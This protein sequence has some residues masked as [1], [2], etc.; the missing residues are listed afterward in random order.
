MPRPVSTDFLQ[1]MRFHVDVVAAD[2][3]PRLLRPVPTG[4]SYPQSGF[5][6][7]TIPSMSVDTVDYREGTF[8]YTRRQ[9]GIPSMEDIT[10]SRGVA[11]GDSSFF[12]WMRQVVEGTG[13]YRATLEIRHY[14]RDNTHIRSGQFPGQFPATNRINQTTIPESI[15]ASAAARTYQVFEAFP[16]N[17]KPAGDLE[18]TTAEI[19]I[20]DITVAYEHFEVLEGEAP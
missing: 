10:L 13:E 17:V 5:S 6:Q 20:Q 11:R 3:T 12:D 16:T 8:I 14:H 2:N 15:L 19:N 7:V 1:S 4:A 18:A 9:P